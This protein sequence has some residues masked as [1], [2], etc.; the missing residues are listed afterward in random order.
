MVVQVILSL[1]LPPCWDLVKFEYVCWH[2]PGRLAIV[3]DIRR[4]ATTDSFKLQKSK[5]GSEGQSG[6]AE[7][8]PLARQF[9][10]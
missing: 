6:G 10:V 7:L 3:A 2:A 1:E 5:M 9:V 8:W 4:L